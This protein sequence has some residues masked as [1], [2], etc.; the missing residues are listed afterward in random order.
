MKIFYYPI[1]WNDSCKSLIYENKRIGFVP[2]MGAIHE[3]HLSLIKKSNIE[4]DITVVS[5]FVNKFQFNDPKDYENYPIEIE[6]DITILEK[7][8][9]DY[10]FLPST[11][12]MYPKDFSYKIVENNLSNILCGKSRPG[13]FE[14]VLTIVA[15]LLNII[16]PHSAYFGEKDYQQYLLIDNMVKSLLMNVRIV[17]CQTVRESDGLAL[18]SINLLLSQNERELAANFPR[19][20]SSNISIEEKT[21]KLSSLGFDVDYVEEQFDRIFGAVKIGNV[22]L[23]DNVK[24]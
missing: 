8:N 7:N 2:T 4:N 5:I 13:H 23:I 1:E 15:K 22:R 11:Q 12:T 6:S 24:K 18:S 10:L 17:S 3:G 9:V 21:K 19:I 20:L 16:K 14:G